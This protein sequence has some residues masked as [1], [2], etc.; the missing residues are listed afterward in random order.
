M[1]SLPTSSSHPLLD[2]DQAQEVRRHLAQIVASKE[3]RTTRR[4]RQFLEYIV[5]RAL[6]GRE[7]L[8]KER[9]IGAEVFGRDDTYDPSADSIVRVSAN[10]VRKRLAAFYQS[11]PASPLSIILPPGSYMPEF[12][13]DPPTKDP[14]LPPSSKNW[15]RSRIWFSLAAALLVL[16]ALAMKSAP[17]DPSP[18]PTALDR[19]WLGV[20]KDP[21]PVLIGL[22]HSVA[23]QPRTRNWNRSQ[24][25]PPPP[26]SEMVRLDD[27]YVS[28][29]DAMV[30]AR[31]SEM[32]AR[33]HRP[34]SVRIGN[35]ISFGD[36]RGHPSVLIGAFNNQWTL[37]MSRDFRFSFL[38]ESLPSGQERLSVVDRE[39]SARPWSLTRVWPSAASNVD[40]A[41]VTRV[42]DPHS[43]KVMVF[44]AGILQYGTEAAGSFLTDPS[45]FAEFER[46]APVNWETR[47][48]QVV[49][50]TNIIRQAAAIPRVLAVHVWDR[51]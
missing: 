38:A 15:S 50:Q 4:G 43:G 9:A 22:G 42:F 32:F 26:T 13:W 1:I 31:L 21:Q 24:P 5:E 27:R 29:A 14:S 39:N 33:R 8:L 19:F 41:I 11:F 46:R 47:N 7:D 3:F 35:G 34:L 48:L 17:G 25:A 49:L 37:E 51:Q 20:I 30:A 45:A 10:D 2:R 28:A 44:V 40:Y 12:R 23:Y 18:P 16:L 6:E 36:L